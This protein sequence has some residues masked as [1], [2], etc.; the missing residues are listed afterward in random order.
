MTNGPK[1]AEAAG[2]ILLLTLIGGFLGL[3]RDMVI[4]G[5]IG[6]SAQYDAFLVGMIIPEGVSTVLTTAIPASFIP[7]V[8]SYLHKQKERGWRFFS[9]TLT[10]LIFSLLIFIALYMVT[11]SWLIRVIAP[12]FS[13]EMHHLAIKLS[14]LL[15]P[16]IF[17]SG[18]A[19]L[20]SAML[21]SYQRFALP[22][23]GPII[24]NLSIIFFLIGFSGRLGI[25]CLIVGF[26]VGS[27]FH[28]L[29]Q[30][31]PLFN[32][33]RFRLTFDLSS[34]D[35]KRLKELFLPVFTMLIILYLNAVIVRVFASHLPAGSISALQYANSL[36]MLPATLIAGSAGT[37]LLPSMSILADMKD[38]SELIRYLRLTLKLMVFILAPI[39]VGI[40]ILR[41]P[42]VFI[43]F[44]RGA[45]DFDDTKVVSTL[46]AYYLGVMVAFP[47]CSIFRQFLYASQYTK[48]LI[49]I[50][51]IFVSFQAL[52]CFF[53]M[54]TLGL[55]GLAL[56]ASLAMIFNAL[57]LYREIEKRIGR[58]V[59][60]S[61]V[62]SFLT[63]VLV[64]F[65]AGF[66]TFSV[67]HLIS[68][69]NFSQVKLFNQLFYLGL[70]LS[71]GLLTFIVFSYLF[72][73]EELNMV[74][75]VLHNRFIR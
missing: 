33:G 55:N 61:L 35:T 50:S 54:Q 51:L 56:A 45:F 6:I 62:K 65:I 58:I 66:S 18:V 37:A 29:V 60:I 27:L 26:L 75:K 32:K 44:E 10:L 47:L 34:P 38:K 53:L 2:L 42:I 69:H 13:G 23:V 73:M 49:R 31:P 40:L 17:L 46:L 15:L 9:N 1:I 59:N 4:A 68:S 8:S 21:N 52:C 7:I 67:Y 3:A 71:I 36:M 22:A 72:R 28:I 25:A 20:F 70:P 57:L 5:K 39:L 19:I 30:V 24:L 48:P 16:F 74:K 64:S 11:M 12:G 41:Y 63:T 14:H 43:L